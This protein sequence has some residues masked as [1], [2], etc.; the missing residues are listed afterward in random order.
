M[1]DRVIKACSAKGA[2]CIARTS[3]SEPRGCISQHHHHQTIKYLVL[4]ILKW[5]TSHGSWVMVMDE[6]V[7]QGSSLVK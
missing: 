5:D 7:N 2:A 3:L 6:L 1:V 4:L